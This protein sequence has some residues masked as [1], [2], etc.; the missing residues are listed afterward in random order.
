MQQFR[1]FSLIILALVFVLAGCQ[2]EAI[3]SPSDEVYASIDA[4]PQG[5]SNPIAIAPVPTSQATPEPNE[6]LNCHSDQQRL[7]DTA[8][9][10]EVVESESSGVG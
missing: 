10:E 3:T 7:I 8:K 2:G 6:C 4:P 1:W 9:P 5:E